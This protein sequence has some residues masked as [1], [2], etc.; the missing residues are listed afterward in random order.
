MKADNKT[1]KQIIAAKDREILELKA[2]LA[3][4]YHFA[5]STI[6]KAGNKHMTGS[7]V[8]LQITALGGREIVLP[9]MIKDGLSEET[10]NALKSDIVRSYELATL[11]K[12]L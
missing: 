3:H 10:I 6:D 11:F 2:Q 8:L 7:G 12:P 1:K 5:K 9:V 4:V